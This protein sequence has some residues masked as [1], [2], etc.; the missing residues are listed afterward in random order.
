M[1]S[2]INFSDEMYVF[3]KCIH[4]LKRGAGARTKQ[5][6]SNEI[7]SVDKIV[8]YD[9]KSKKYQFGSPQDFINFLDSASPT[10]TLVSK[11]LKYTAKCMQLTFTERTNKN[12]QPENQPQIQP[13]THDLTNYNW[14]DLETCQWLLEVDPVETPDDLQKKKIEK[15]SEKLAKSDKKI[16]LRHFLDLFKMEYSFENL[17]F[18]SEPKLK[19]LCFIE[20]RHLKILFKM[21]ST[22][23][24]FDRLTADKLL[25]SWYEMSNSLEIGF[26]EM[27]DNDS[28]IKKSKI[29]FEKPLNLDERE[30]VK[31]LLYTLVLG[32]SDLGVKCGSFVEKCRFRSFQ[33]DLGRFRLLKVVLSSLVH[34]S[35]FG[36]L[37]ALKFRVKGMIHLNVISLTIFKNHLVR[38]WFHHGQPL[39]RSTEHSKEKKMQILWLC[40]PDS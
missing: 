5:S 32:I 17:K 11:N 3:M 13:K 23:V 29:T 35:D 9:T 34:F 39:R 8:F 16:Y 1:N 4:E 18:R 33:V 38:C 6:K 27:I 7:C 36:S 31:H 37:Q 25:K 21:E 28:V 24:P 26:Q 10:P 20:M 40:L 2:K 30:T 19:E 15:I 22:G 12:I 14:F